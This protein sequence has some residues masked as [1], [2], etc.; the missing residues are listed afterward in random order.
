MGFHLYVRSFFLRVPKLEFRILRP[1]DKTTV[2]LWNGR[3][4]SYA[5]VSGRVSAAVAR[6]IATPQRKYPTSYPTEFHHHSTTE[7][8]SM[9]QCSWLPASVNI[10]YQPPCYCLLPPFPTPYQRSADWSQKRN[11]FSLTTV[12]DTLGDEKSKLAAFCKV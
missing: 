5:G 1:W 10:Q 4:V 2:M 7:Q 12:I 8:D 3:K 6:A 11:F 9:E